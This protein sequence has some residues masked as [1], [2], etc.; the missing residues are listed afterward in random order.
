MLTQGCSIN[1]MMG[2]TMSRYAQEHMVPYLLAYGD[3]EAACGTGVAMGSFLNSFERVTTPPHKAAVPT[4]LSA[5]LCAQGAAWEAELQRLRHISNKNVAGAVDARIVEQRQH[6]V[7]AR[8]LYE[9]YTRTVAEFGSPKVGCPQLDTKFD[10]LVW[11]LGML[12]AIQGVQHDR[13]ANGAVGIPL[14]APVHAA[15]GTQCL[16]N[17]AWW[18]VPDAIKAAIWATIPGSGPDDA[19]PWSV[20][21]TAVKIGD[22]KGVRLAHAIRIQTADAGGHKDKVVEALKAMAESLERVAPSAR[23]LTFDRIAFV[24][25]RVVSDRIWTKAT[26][27]RTP[28]GEFGVLPADEIGEPEADDDLLE[29]L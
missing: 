18:G 21:D 15:R 28:Y 4:L 19:D 24:Q 3:T 20:L 12:S 25:A 16:N 26:G 10:E 2:D 11:L 8:R 6:E 17:E 1:G 9:S 13:G 5:A 27:S 29:G 22:K 7:A 14:D 23:W